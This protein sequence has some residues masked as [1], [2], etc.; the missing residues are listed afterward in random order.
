MKYTFLVKIIQTDFGKILENIQNV[1]KLAKV[2][3]N[4]RESSE[5]F[6]FVAI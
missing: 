6:G 5:V 3:Q 2:N 4:P 1:L